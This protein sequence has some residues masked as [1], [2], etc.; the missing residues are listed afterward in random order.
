M[1]KKLR[2]KILSVKESIGKKIWVQKHLRFKKILVKE[3][4]D[5]QNLIQKN[6]GQII[7]SKNLT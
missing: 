1:T 6:F 7:W 4:S 5:K 2:S 3:A